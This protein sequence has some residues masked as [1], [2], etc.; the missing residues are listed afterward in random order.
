MGQNMR[1]KKHLMSNTGVKFAANLMRDLRAV[2]TACESS[3]VRPL[4]SAEQ[5]SLMLKFPVPRAT[6]SHPLASG[7][8][9]ESE[10]SGLPYIHITLLVATLATY[11]VKQTA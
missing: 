11:T 9:K 4:D 1:Q 3:T 8:R 7:G 6:T 5:L 2:T 10:D